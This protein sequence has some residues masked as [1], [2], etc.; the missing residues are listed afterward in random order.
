MRLGN[1]HGHDVCFNVQTAVDS[2]NGLVSAVIVTDSCNDLN[3]LSSVVAEARQTIAMTEPDE[4]EKDETEKK[5]A[6]EEAAATYAVESKEQDKVIV[7]ADTGYSNGAEIRKC[8][9]ENAECRIPQPKPSHQPKNEHFHRDKFKYDKQTDTVTCPEGNVM[10]HVRNRKRDNC[11]VYAN[12]DACKNCPVKEDCTRSETLREIERTP[13]AEYTQ[14][15][16]ARVK[17]APDLFGR[18]K[19]LSEHPFGVVKHSMGYGHFLC[20]G[21][22]K[23]TAEISLAFLAFN[24]RRVINIVGISALIAAING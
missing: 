16:N 7:L 3:E 2:E 17:N 24:F 22:E 21:I 14:K 8:E 10:S 12:R 23:V 15:A 19:E 9:D 18:R 6:N 13:D 4:T 1:G 20:K 11:A 5:E